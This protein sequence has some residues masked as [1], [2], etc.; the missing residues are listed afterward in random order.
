MLSVFAVFKQF[1]VF[2]CVRACVWNSSAG[3]E[4]EAGGHSRQRHNR[5]G[6]DGGAAAAGSLEKRIEEL[7]K[8][9]SL[10]SHLR[11]CARRRGHWLRFHSGRLRHIWLF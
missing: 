9:R 1:L 5:H 3:A 11:R 6:R 4:E 8:V 2:V 10:M 7:E